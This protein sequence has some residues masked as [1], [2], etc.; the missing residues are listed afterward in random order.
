MTFKRISSNCDHKQ[1]FVMPINPLPT[2][3]TRYSSSSSAKFET[4]IL[5]NDF[6]GIMV[7]ATKPIVLLKI[8][9][10]TAFL[11]IYS[12]NACGICSHMDCNMRCTDKCEIFNCCLLQRI[13]V[14]GL[15]SALTYQP[16]LSVYFRY[17]VSAHLLFKIVL[18]YN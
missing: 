3:V 14:F 18:C 10:Q 16:K 13:D 1:L 17:R 6:F 15:L 2:T 4:M 11:L 7:E 9:I 5:Y 12:T 8:S